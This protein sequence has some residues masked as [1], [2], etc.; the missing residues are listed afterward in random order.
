MSE[1]VEMSDAILHAN[2]VQKKL[3]NF[4]DLTGLK[5]QLVDRVIVL[6]GWK[7]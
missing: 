3:V 5:Y 1:V 6:D 4:P 2:D 7:L